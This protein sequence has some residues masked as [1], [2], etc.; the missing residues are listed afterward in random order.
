MVLSVHTMMMCKTTAKMMAS[1]KKRVQ[2]HGK[3]KQVLM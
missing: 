1:L 3:I 2:K